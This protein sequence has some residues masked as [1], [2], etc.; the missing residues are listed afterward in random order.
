MFSPGENVRY[1]PCKVQNMPD[2][3]LSPAAQH[4]IN[5]VLIWVGFGAL[6][7]LLATVL[8]PLRR[9]A[10]PFWAV[11]LGIAGSTI[12]LLGLSWL[13]PGRPIN[14]FSP[15]GFLA[16]TLGAFVLLMLHHIGAAMLTRP[17]GGQDVAGSDSR[18][19]S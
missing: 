9:P 2:L 5:V 1:W 10:G 8:F 16:A 4:W 18:R 3:P 13:F 11:V 6:A 19:R 7:G 17:D 14:P 12:G 15:L